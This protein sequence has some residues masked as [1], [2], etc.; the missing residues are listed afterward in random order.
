MSVE[1]PGGGQLWA[2]RQVRTSGPEVS[3]HEDWD[4][5]GCKA[6]PLPYSIICEMGVVSLPRS[7]GPQQN[8]HWLGDNCQ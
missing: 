3:W 8:G 6:E 1:T 4:A 5:G 7:L 2:C